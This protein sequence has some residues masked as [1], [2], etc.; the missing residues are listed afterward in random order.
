MVPCSTGSPE[1]RQSEQ[2]Q[3]TCQTAKG[4][5]S[6][7]N[8]ETETQRRRYMKKSSIA[9][10]GMKDRKGKRARKEWKMRQSKWKDQVW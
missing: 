10:K 1:W 6:G 2:I 9:G 3:E 5:R 7:E 4:E 8:K